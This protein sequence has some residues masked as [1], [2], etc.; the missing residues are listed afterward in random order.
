MA[1]AAPSEDGW[2]DLT[3]AARDLAPLH[4]YAPSIA[5]S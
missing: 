1:E 3:G 2:G 4:A 5:S